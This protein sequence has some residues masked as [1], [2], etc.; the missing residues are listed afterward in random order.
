MVYEVTAARRRPQIFEELVGQE[1]VTATLQ[2]AVKSGKIAHAYL[3]SGP[4]GCGK[5]T[6]ARI[7]A[8]L[9]NCEK[10]PAATPCGVCQS[11]LEIARGASLDVIEIDGASNTSVNDVRQIKDEILFPPNSCRYKIYIIDEVHMLSVSA[12]NAL[13]KTIEEPPP[14]VVFIF[15]TTE[16]HKVP[17]T[18]K[19]RCQ[20]FH[21]RLGSVEQIKELLSAAAA[22]AGIQADSEA[23]YWIA[24]ESTGSFR[25]AYTLF[26]QVA[27]F[28]DG[29]IT[30][31]KIRDKLGLVGVERFNELCELCVSGNAAPVLEKLDEILQNGVSIEQFTANA[32]DYLRSLL[33][34]QNGIKKEALL[35]Q[36]A[37][38]FS[39]K[40]LSAWNSVQLERALSLF[41]QLFRDIRYSLNPRYELELVLS[42]LTW[43]SSYVTASDI[44]RVIG[45]IRPMLTGGASGSSASSASAVSASSAQTPSVSLP[46]QMPKFSILSDAAPDNGSAGQTE[47]S[48]VNSFPFRDSGRREPEIPQSAAAVG[49]EYFSE[50]QT[51]DAFAASSAGAE[52]IIHAEYEHSAAPLPDRKLL[53][54]D[55][56]RTALMEK[57]SVSEMSLSSAVAQTSGWRIKDGT[58]FVT[59]R[60]PFLQNQLERKKH[61]IQPL[62]ASLWGAPLELTVLLEKAETANANEQL[63]P[64]AALIKEM[65]DGNCVSAADINHFAVQNAAVYAAE[66]T[67]EELSGD[68]FDSEAEETDSAP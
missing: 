45:G 15:A 10:G 43:L 28:S 51:A 25:D 39:A 36:T 50:K 23:L 4:R 16:L 64:Q 2:N 55:E 63:P 17:A 37:D 29:H 60:M 58:L 21:F 67:E 34:L 61:I 11:C 35:G 24:R 1:F 6:S 49:N 41:L 5:T 47:P 19:S 66:K 53:S 57:L 44:Q 68:F 56:L 20:Q 62:A 26:D 12:F 30:Y 8:K 42:K 3:F 54:A 32:A 18:I 59:S 9:L 31:E 13:L 48:R 27:A 7:L 40:V 38:R 14:Y 22:E 65:F 46:P 52:K 33:L